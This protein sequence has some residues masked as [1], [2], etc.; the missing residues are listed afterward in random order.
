MK[1]SAVVITLNEEK[2]ITA[3]LSSLSFVDEIIVVDSGSTDKTEEICRSYP[4]V[5]FFS[6]PWL[7]FGPQKNYAVSLATHEWIFSIDADEV[8][9][10]DLADEISTMMS[11][12]VECDAFAINRR[13]VYRNQ[14]IQH[15]GW[16]PD[17]VLR[18]FRKTAGAFSTRMV[19]ESV[20]VSGPVLRLR[21]P[22]EHRP[23]NGPEDFILKMHSYSMA[24]AR[25]LLEEGKRGSTTHAFLRGCAAF[26][27]GYILKRGFMDGHAGLLIAVSGAVGVFYKWMK[28]TELCA[29]SEN[30]SQAGIF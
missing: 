13:N 15:G 25:Q 30:G 20:Q 16:W 3:C 24:G 8:V 12:Y 18:L 10:P 5:K 26:V 1:I 4:R 22:L 28:L 27:K 6:Q 23:Y 17:Q 29:K 2:K 14:W 19:H 9:T 11:S 21:Y 7:G